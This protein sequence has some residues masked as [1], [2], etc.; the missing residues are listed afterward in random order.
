M[1]HATD[2]W[3]GAGFSSHA[4]SRLSAPARYA[5][6]GVGQPDLPRLCDCVASDNMFRMNS[7][8]GPASSTAGTTLTMPAGRRGSRLGRMLRSDSL[9]SSSAREVADWQRGSQESRDQRY[10]QAEL[11]SVGA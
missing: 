10:R 2:N 5:T 7:D 3:R 1:N 6:D 9:M 8:R 4:G 11:Q